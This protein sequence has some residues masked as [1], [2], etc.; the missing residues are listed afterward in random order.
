[1][2]T[3]LANA[4]EFVLRDVFRHPVAAIVGEIELLGSGFQSKPTVL[5]TPRAITS[6]PEPSRFIRL[7][8]PWASSCI[9]LL[10]GCPTGT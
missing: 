5:R 6:A 7:I 10:P 9:T 3:N 2:L 8:W 4:V 1:M